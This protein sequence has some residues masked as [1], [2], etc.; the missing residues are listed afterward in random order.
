MGNLS[1][2]SERDEQER[3][4]KAQYQLNRVCDKHGIQLTA[5]EFSQMVVKLSG[6]DCDDRYATEVV[7]QTLRQGK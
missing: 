2:E 1:Y 4:L 7:V 6:L 5:D 3:R